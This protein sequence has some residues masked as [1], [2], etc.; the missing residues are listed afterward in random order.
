MGVGKTVFIK[1]IGEQ[2]GINN[3]ISPT[4]VIY[5]EYG[6]F[7]HFDLYQIENK[8]EFKHLGI[9]NLLKPGNILCFE[10]G[11]KAGDIIELLKEKGRIV[12]VRMEYVDEKTR[13][14]ITNNQ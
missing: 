8:N 3:I 5:Y 13:R 9:K 6:N 11:E 1:G 12:Y 14:I 7:Y 10:W 4:F 2:L